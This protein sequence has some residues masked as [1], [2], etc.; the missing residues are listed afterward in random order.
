MNLKISHVSRKSLMSVMV[1]LSLC[2]SPTIAFKPAEPNYGHSFI[3]RSVATE[4]YRGW[5]SNEAAFEATLQV[6]G[7]KLRFT[8][9]AVEHLV[10]GVQ[11]VDRIP[12]SSGL[13]PN[14]FPSEVFN[15]L[16]VPVPGE[17]VFPQAHCDDELILDCSRRLYALRSGNVQ[18]DAASVATQLEKDSAVNLLYRAA[19][20]ELDPNETDARKSTA[21]GYAVAA[22]VH[23][24]RALHTL[25]DFYAHSNWSDVVGS[26]AFFSELGK[27]ENQGVIPAGRLWEQS[28]E[29]PSIDVCTARY[30]SDDV[31][32]AY[33]IDLALSY[34]SKVAAFLALA[35]TRLFTLDWSNTGGNFE[36][37]AQVLTNGTG[38]AAGAKVTSGYFDI[39][40]TFAAGIESAPNQPAKCDHG[41]EPAAGKVLGINKDMPENPRSPTGQDS[42]TAASPSSRHQHASLH[43]ARHTFAFFTSV[44]ADIDSKVNQAALPSGVSKA[45]LR[46]HMVELF[47]GARPVVAFV[48][49]YTGSMQDIIEGLADRVQA[50][51]DAE[52][53]IEV[54]VVD[55]LT[56]L[57]LG[58]SYQTDPNRKFS[59]FTYGENLVGGV[60][61]K[62]FTAELLGSN[63]IYGKAADV[64][65]RLRSTA[66]NASGGGD[67]KEPTFSAL[68]EAIKRTPKGSKLFVFT[69]AS[70]K[71][72]LI[73]GGGATPR[74]LLESAEVERLAKVK[75]LEIVFSVSGSCSPVDPGY[76]AVARGTGGQLVLVDH[77][78]DDTGMALGNLS[79]GRSL[80]QP[81]HVESGNLAPGSGKSIAIPVESGASV[82]SVTVTNDSQGFALR[83]PQ[84]NAV[85]LT[86]F[87]G[88][89]MA[90]VAAP[91][92]GTWLLGVSG[93]PV[94]TGSA[95]SAYSVRA[96]IQG[97]FH[98]QGVHYSALSEA[99]RVGHL[100]RDP[101]G[102]QVPAQSVYM[103]A[104]LT[105]SNN[106]QAATYTWQAVTADGQLIGNLALTRQTTQDY[107]GHVALG[108]ITAFG[109]R[110]FRVR[111]VGTDASGQPF[112][113]VLPTLQEAQS[114]T[115]TA[116]AAPN[117]WVT[118]NTYVVRFALTN[119]AATADAFTFKP[120]ISLGSVN[121]NQSGVVSVAAGATAEVAMTVQLPTNAS[122]TQD[123]ALSIDVTSANGGN[124][125]VA[126]LKLPFVVL[127]DQDGDGVPDVVE[128]GPSGV[129]PSYDANGDGIPDW[130]QAAVISLYSQG[131][132]A[133]LNA[134]LSAGEFRRARAV[135]AEGTGSDKHGLG[136]FDFQVVNLSPGATTQM[137]VTLPGSMTAQGY[138]KYGPTPANSTPHYYEFARDDAL[139]VGATVKANVITVKLRDGA[140]GDDDLTA[141]GVIV[142]AGG[143]SYPVFASASSQSTPTAGMP[144]TPST[145]AAGGSAGGGGC[146]I[147]APGQRDGSLVLLT[148]L[149]AGVLWRRRHGG[150]ASGVQPAPGRRP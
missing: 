141:D 150:R 14:L 92:A 73:M 23:V 99:G 139:G 85:A 78:A 81:V 28:P 137:V 2:V 11:Q 86:R 49:D 1:A 40:K 130:K 102:E 138:G 124:V 51:A 109:T 56:G 55:P 24:G 142:D 123:Q 61:K 80:M 53:Q 126:S 57:P 43:A 69:D 110:A 111:V 127:S 32:L 121:L 129:D 131:R 149:A 135:S 104:E 140:L 107:S 77:T 27:S 31:F 117:Y 144:S 19:Y 115:L 116:V 83:D 74:Q 54:P 13:L 148:A 96:Q 26:D 122:V 90:R 36:Y 112:A 30:V 41:L 125:S 71:D 103:D 114:T 22:R 132:K 105:A 94:T 6:T 146:T 44:I 48:V 52:S 91:A 17:I 4:G 20:I 16:G 59:L 97:A 70:S 89:A 128:M 120:A 95:A 113:R 143:P 34:A 147:G 45:E 9:A 88:G 46:D 67:C 98:L 29:A 118:G 7:D 18:S 76:A 35:A 66:A 8:P 134:V 101:Y 100:I 50:I 25:Q 68:L 12:P 79:A 75:K 64:A 84:G 42:G 38:G 145:P 37:T 72:E 136:L 3:T 87:L 58:T 133:Y 119:N 108:D 5:G 10:A 63:S 106:N 82:L 60:Y 62:H 47:M 15:G 65:S 39:G 33:Q 93:F 21:D